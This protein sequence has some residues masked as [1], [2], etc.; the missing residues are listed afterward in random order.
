MGSKV[1]GRRHSLRV[2]SV[3]ACILVLANS[4]SAQQLAPPKKTQP[5]QED[6][7]VTSTSASKR[8]FQTC[9]AR[10]HQGSQGEMAKM[11]RCDRPR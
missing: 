1:C 8:C 10:F 9:G 7:S 4:Q 11:R 5:Q 6:T 3:G 2:L